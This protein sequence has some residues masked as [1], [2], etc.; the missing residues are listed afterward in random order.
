MNEYIALMNKRDFCT[1]KALEF[2]HK[3]DI[4]MFTFWG[5]AA[6]EYERRAREL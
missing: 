6:R 3:G 5:N 4:Y 1:R 2:L